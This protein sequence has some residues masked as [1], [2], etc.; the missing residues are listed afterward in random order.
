[1]EI[2]ILGYRINLE[3]LIL[4]GIMYLIL[5]YHTV[6]PCVNMPLLY[7]S[8]TN[9]VTTPGA[10]AGATSAAAKTDK[11]KVPVGTGSKKEGFSS[12]YGA[13]NLDDA[14]SYKL[15]DY[16]MPDV[17][18][19]FQ[20]NLTVSPGKPLSAGVKEVL[21]RPGQPVPLPE[22]ELL[23]FANTEF[24]PEYCPNTYSNGSGCAGMTV[25]QYNY[26]QTRG[27]NNVPYSE[28]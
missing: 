6:C 15:G 28:Y 3:V 4:I 8:L 20:P 26:L 9:M 5:I 10:K 23:M 11:E 21:S 13:Y 16:S 12:G 18:K 25:Q 27:G 22:G 14:A 1:M 2:S 19:W 17:S 24:K 7:E